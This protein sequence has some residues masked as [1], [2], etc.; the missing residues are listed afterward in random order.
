MR[1]G[2]LKRREFITMV[3]GAA[4]WPLAA[5]QAIGFPGRVFRGLA[6]GALTSGRI[7]QRVG[8]L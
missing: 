4:G 7:Q 8:P 6:A 2:Q 3:D 1:F 5:Q